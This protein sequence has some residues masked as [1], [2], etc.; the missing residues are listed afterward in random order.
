[1]QDTFLDS[2]TEGELLALPYLFEF[3][4][5]NHQMPPNGDWRTWVIM[6]GRGAGKTRAGAEWVRAQ[7]EGSKPLEAGRARRVALLG[8][9]IDQVREVMIFGESGI[10]ACSPS[11]RRPRWEPG[12]KRLIWPNGAVAS[13]HSAFDSEGLRG[14]QFDAAWADELGCAAIDK[15]TNQPNKF[16]DP[17]SSESRLP[18]FSNGARDDF[19]QT[20]YLRAMASFWADE[21][22]NPVSESYGGAMVDM[23]R[24]FVWA[25]DAR[26]Y[27]YFPNNPELWSDSD[28]YARGHWLNGRT[29]ARSL[30]SVVAEICDRTGLQFYDVSGLYGTVRGYL[31]NDVSEARAS[32]QPLMLRYGFDAVER[33][34]VLIFRM[35]TGGKPV[36]LN[37]ETLALS[38][39]LDASVEQMRKADAEISGRVRLRFLQADAGFDVLSEEAVLA[40]EKTTRFPPPK[41]QW[42]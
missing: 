32:L 4:A 42:L 17:K 40:E 38:S 18:K 24:A 30:A 34:G 2:L 25:W 21:Q 5:M 7:V 13:V 35:R 14:P 41:F 26:P 28:N 10:L 39:D 37:R 29:S 15:G 11:D 8:E 9:T 23:S 3:W 16:L 33:D 6:G 31:V 20:Q 22:N 36:P 27:P 12:R 19:I 1:M